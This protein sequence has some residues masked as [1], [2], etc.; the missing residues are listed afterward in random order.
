MNNKAFETLKQAS[1]LI[2]AVFASVGVAATAVLTARATPKAME[3]IKADSRK[4]HDGDSEAFTKR[5]AVQA[6]WKYYIPAVAV[7]GTT[8]ACIFG[9]HGLDK[10]QQ[11]ALLSTYTLLHSTYKSYQN[12]VKELYGEEAHENILKN[13]MIE[14]SKDVCITADNLLTTTC[15]DFEDADEDEYL[16]YDMYSNRYFTT[17]ISRVLQAEYHLNR[18][19]TISG[20]VSVNNFYDF[21]GIEKMPEGNSLGWCC[22]CSDA[23]GYLWIDFDHYKMEVEPGMNCYVIEM[24][25]EPTD[26]SE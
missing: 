3:A 25:F 24:V 1:P 23:E 4:N 11:A 6:S 19:F 17:A 16:F 12:Q 13:A 21:L 5:E 8:I 18:N 14:Q 22:D 7:G 20:M 9:V 26:I 15:L 2:L 10:R